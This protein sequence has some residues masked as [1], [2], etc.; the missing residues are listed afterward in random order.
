MKHKRAKYQNKL[1]KM[2]GMTVMTRVTGM[3]VATRVIGMTEIT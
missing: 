3:T 1:I 2:T